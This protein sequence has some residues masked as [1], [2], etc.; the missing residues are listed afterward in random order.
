MTVR[1]LKRVLQIVVAVWDALYSDVFTG[2]TGAAPASVWTKPTTYP[3]SGTVTIQSNAMRISTNSTTAWTPAASVVLGNPSAPGTAPKIMPDV[4][5]TF[6]YTLLNV[7][8]HYPAITVRARSA[9]LWNGGGGGNSPTTGYAIIL[10]PL[11]QKFDVITGYNSTSVLPGGTP[12]A[13]TIVAAMK[14]RIRIEGKRLAFKAWPAASAE[15]TAWTYDNPTLLQDQSDG[16]IAFAVANGPAAE[17]KTVTIDN[18][19]AVSRPLGGYNGTQAAP[20]A[21]VAGFTKGF[22]E[23]FDTPAAAGSGAG[24]FATVYANSWT[25]YAASG[26]MSPL[27]QIS[28]HDSVF[29]L[30]MD[31][32]HAAA[33]WFGPSATSQSYQ[34]GRF[35]MRAKCIG[36]WGNGPAIMIWPSSNTW[37]EGE[38]DFPESVSGDG[39]SG[40]QDA[41][42][43]HHHKMVAGQESQAQ[44][45]PLNVSWRDWH[46]Y[47]CEWYPPGKGPTP[48]TGS[49]TYYV[50]GVQV[51]TT[52]TD[53]PTTAHRYT[54]QVGDYGSA[55]NLYIDWVR[56]DTVT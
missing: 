43:I 45:V 5:Y 10:Q 54:V 15:P 35:S 29:D 46:E 37:A 38:I 51:Y 32:A 52:T 27:T 3:T 44:D 11:E 1:I 23:N 41:P 47:A 7:S 31:G 34:G 19:T 21:A 36:A 13:L 9:E 50:D 26:T 22:V 18:F 16:T 2:T 30:A 25:N 17:A 4:E 55:G 8:Q 48:S 39:K 14:W 12:V 33:G 24:Q 40:F 56:I 28:A 6:D 42:W 53:V 49:V 20:T